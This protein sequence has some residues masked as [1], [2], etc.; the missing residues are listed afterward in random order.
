MLKYQNV[1]PNQYEIV[2]L[3]QVTGEVGVKAFQSRDLDLAFKI[4]ISILLR[5]H[6]LNIFRKN[7]CTVLRKYFW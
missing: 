3:S 2:S 1:V 5:S 7:T 4:V 6:C